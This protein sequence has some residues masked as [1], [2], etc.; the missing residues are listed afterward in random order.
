M[1]AAT[2]GLH[3]PKSM[4]LKITE[5]LA[6][7]GSLACTSRG[8][9]L[10]CTEANDELSVCCPSQ[11]FHHPGETDLQDESALEEESC[12]YPRDVRM[13]LNDDADED[14]VTDWMGLNAYDFQQ[15]TAEH[16]LRWS[17]C[18]S[19][20]F[21]TGCIRNRDVPDD[22][23]EAAMN[24]NERA[25]IDV[26]ENITCNSGDPN[27]DWDDSIYEDASTHCTCGYADG[28]YT[29]CAC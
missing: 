12:E 27:R 8:A 16:N 2:L 5:Y 11:Q 1:I 28:L 4:D 9:D 7:T 18:G 29:Y 24:S 22:E 6:H 23:A 10:I 17:C 26:Y 13:K 14:D 19:S 3:L 15:R 20:F 25:Q 21:S